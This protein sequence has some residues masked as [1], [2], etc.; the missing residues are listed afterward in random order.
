M[1]TKLSPPDEELYRRV[2]EILHYIWDPIGISGYPRA[3]D[4]YNTYLPRVFGL[5]KENANAE[6]IAEYLFEVSTERMGP[7][8]RRKKDLEVAAILLDWNAVVNKGQL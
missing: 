8:E 3:P 2:D 4:E 1:G 7:N 6:R 5:L